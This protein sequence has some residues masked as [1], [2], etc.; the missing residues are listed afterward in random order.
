[1]AA[2][3]A[4]ERYEAVVLDS[5]H[6]E[7]QVWA[8]FQLAAQLVC[9]GG[10][11]L[12]HDAVYRHGTV[13]AALRRIEDAGFNVVRLWTADEGVREDDRLGLAVIENRCRPQSGVRVSKT[14]TS[15]SDATSLLVADQGADTSQGGAW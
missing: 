11:I 5:L 7:T 10:L 15:L 1:Q 2:L 3:D 8:E 9:Q 14:D 4:D 6:T 13:P 12:I